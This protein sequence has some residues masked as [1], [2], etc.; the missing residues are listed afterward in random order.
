MRA[1]F[2]KAELGS[3][4]LPPFTCVDRFFR[5][6]VGH[7]SIPAPNTGKNLIGPVPPDTD[8]EPARLAAD[9]HPAPIKP[10]PIAAFVPKR[11]QGADEA[12][13]NR[14]LEGTGFKLLPPPSGLNAG[15]KVNLLGRSLSAQGLRIVT[16]LLAEEVRRLPNEVREV[17]RELR[18]AVLVSD[19][20][21]SQGRAWIN[22]RLLAFG[23]SQY[24]RSL[25][26]KAFIDDLIAEAKAGAAY[27]IGS[28]DYRHYT[29]AT[30]ATV[31]QRV[32]QNTIRH[33]IGHLLTS[34]ASL[35][36]LYAFMER[37]GID[38]AWTCRNL[39]PYAAQ[40]GRE[41]LA[42]SFSKYHH[43]DYRRGMMPREWEELVEWM[44]YDKLAY[45]DQLVTRK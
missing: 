39:S 11:L 29:P 27:N 2:F 42:E 1:R 6:K 22:L 23:V 34:D 32:M 13:L 3:Q 35:E 8:D 19:V 28:N 9:S 17:L 45:L 41:F 26:G 16:G 10:K 21:K 15:R 36:R 20:S 40:N 31:I 18:P 43:R 44:P 5:K 37:A 7:R 38:A 4:E 14:V 24:A 33:E 25:A 30:R 12:A